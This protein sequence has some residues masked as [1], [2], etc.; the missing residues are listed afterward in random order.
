M[1][2]AFMPVMVIALVGL[3]AAKLAS[4]TGIFNFAR[5]LAGSLGTAIGVTLWDERA[6]FHRSRLAEA[7]S[8]DSPVYQQTLALLSSRTGDPDSA[9]AALE[10]A[11][12]IQARTMALNDLNFLC[13]VA[14]L[15]AAALPWLLPANS[16]PQ[17]P[18]RD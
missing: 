4:A 5:M 2:F 6:I 16:R 13:V 1:P 12:Q 9:M 11:V 14:I 3:P 18:P 15:V 10:G 8:G 7:L 17:E